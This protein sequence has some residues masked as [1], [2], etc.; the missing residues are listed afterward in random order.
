MALSAHFVVAATS[1]SSVAGAISVAFQ[2]E[3]W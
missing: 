3:E 2:F 1:D